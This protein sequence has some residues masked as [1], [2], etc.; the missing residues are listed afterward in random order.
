M[1]ITPRKHCSECNV[2]FINRNTKE[3]DNISIRSSCNLFMQ[4]KKSCRTMEMHIKFAHLTWFL[5]E[6]NV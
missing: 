2:M 3:K 1:N 4:K 5:R 6:Q